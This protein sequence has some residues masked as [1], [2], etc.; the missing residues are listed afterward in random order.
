MITPQGSMQ[1]K[2][3]NRWIAPGHYRQSMQLPF[4]KIDVYYDGKTGW[5]N[6]PQGVMAIPPPIA[7]QVQEGLFRNPYTLLLSDRNPE[8]TV[9]AV[10][11]NA[12]QITDKSGNSVRVDFDG[13]TGLPS[14]LT[15]KSIA[16]TGEPATVTE[17]LSDY[18]PV[19]GIIR[20]RKLTI[21]Q[22]GQKFADVTYT[23]TKINT[24]LTV[25][26]ISQKP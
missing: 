1:G 19:G 23:D 20:P 15:Y 24:G 22:N 17:A 4:G 5:F 18:Q 11:E 10:S 2:Q 8:R 21:E 25:E 3:E 7:K 26:Q 9:A 14:K 12:V 13:S 6:S 16:M